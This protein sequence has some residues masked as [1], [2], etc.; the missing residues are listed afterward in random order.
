MSETVFLLAYDG[1]AVSD[2]EMDVSDLAP[3]LLG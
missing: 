2:G 1:E 3:A